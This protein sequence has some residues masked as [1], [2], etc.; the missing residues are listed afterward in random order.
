MQTKL[1]LMKLKQRSAARSTKQHADSYIRFT[2]TCSDLLVGSGCKSRCRRNLTAATTG[3]MMY[4]IFR[5]ND[6][7]T[8]CLPVNKPRPPSNKPRPLSQSHNRMTIVHLAY[9]S[10]SHTYSAK[11]MMLFHHRQLSVH[12]SNHIWMLIYHFFQYSL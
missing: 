9:L 5:Q 8:P 11:Y 4:G 7:L 1:T 6:H 2:H 10:T 3:I 12:I